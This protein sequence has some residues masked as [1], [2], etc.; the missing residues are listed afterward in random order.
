M[1]STPHIPLQVSDKMNLH[2]TPPAW[3][4]LLPDLDLIDNQHPGILP[5][6]LLL[7]T[8]W[9]LSSWLPFASFMT[10]WTIKTMNTSMFTQI[11][12]CLNN[13]ERPPTELQPCKI[14]RMQHYCKIPHYCH[15]TQW[16]SQRCMISWK[17]HG[18]EQFFSLFDRFFFLCRIC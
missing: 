3:V 9:L 8:L 2:L 13:R 17:P 7:L 18:L 12:A 14:R 5:L 15:S 4:L 11:Y 16:K 6:F 10:L 1:S